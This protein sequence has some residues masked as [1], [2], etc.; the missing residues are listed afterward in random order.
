MACCR[1]YAGIEEHDCDSSKWNPHT[2]M[3]L[4][5]AFQNLAAKTTALKEFYLKQRK[6]WVSKIFVQIPYLVLKQRDF[7]PKIFAKTSFYFK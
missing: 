4:S 7:K 3:I 6:F 2:T 1:A 5:L